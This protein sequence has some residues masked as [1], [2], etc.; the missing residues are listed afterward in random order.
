M[1]G[2][3]DDQRDAR[4]FADL[5]ARFGGD[6]GD[7]QLAEALRQA[8]APRPLSP[9]LAK[10]IASDLDRRMVSGRRRIVLHWSWISTAADSSLMMPIM[11]LTV[12]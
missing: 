2:P 8:L 6:A 5:P 9:R 4:E 1:H 7:E 10:R 3:N 12:S 11:L